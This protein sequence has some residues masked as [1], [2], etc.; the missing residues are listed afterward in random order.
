[1]SFSIFDFEPRLDLSQAMPQLFQLGHRL[2]GRGRLARFVSETP[3]SV[4]LIHHRPNP[5]ERPQHVQHEQADPAGGVDRVLMRMMTRMRDPS[6]NVVDRDDAVDQHDHDEKQ[7]AKCEVIK[8]WIFHGRSPSQVGAERQRTAAVPGKLDI[9]ASYN[10]AF[11]YRGL[12]RGMITLGLIRI[13]QRKF[14]HSRIE[15]VV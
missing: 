1:M 14:S 7:Q 10:L 13:G 15:R 4:R 6:G 2:L 9:L 11:T 5:K 8:E 12:E 3:A